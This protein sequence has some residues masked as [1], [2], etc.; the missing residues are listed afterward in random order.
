MLVSLSEQ[1]QYWLN[2]LQWTILLVIFGVAIAVSVRIHRDEALAMTFILREDGKCE[3]TQ[4][5][6]H[7][8]IELGTYA[9]GRGSRALPIGLYVQLE[10]AFVSRQQFWVLLGELPSTDYYRLSRAVYLAQ[11][12][13]HAEI[14]S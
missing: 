14:L 4:I 11:R 2:G 8:G 5:N 9:I 7:S 3:L 6:G 13:P 12:R 1:I 10:A